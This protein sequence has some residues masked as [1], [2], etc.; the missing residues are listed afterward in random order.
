MTIATQMSSKRKQTGEEPTPTEEPR[1]ETKVALEEVA[2]EEKKEEEKDLSDP[3]NNWL[4][5]KYQAVLE[6]EDKM[7]TQE[8]I[9]KMTAER[10]REEL[11]KGA[12]SLQ[13]NIKAGRKDIGTVK[14]TPPQRLIIQVITPKQVWHP[15]DAIHGYGF[16]LADESDDSGLKPTPGFEDV[17]SKPPK[18][19]DGPETIRNFEKWLAKVDEHQKLSTESATFK[20]DQIPIA[21]FHKIPDLLRGL[22]KYMDKHPSLLV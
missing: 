15:F 2:H 22:Y 7:L 11:E 4:I 10:L 17:P 8:T 18:G 1:K 6:K 19:K 5:R 12:T 21:K 3:A 16:C 13:V 14:V 9:N 20:F